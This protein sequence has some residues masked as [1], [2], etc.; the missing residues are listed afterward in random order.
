MRFPRR[1]H[2]CPAVV[3]VGRRRAFRLVASHANRRTPLER[4]YSFCF[5]IVS[6]CRLLVVAR[7][8]ADVVSARPMLSTGLAS[9]RSRRASRHSDARFAPATSQSARRSRLASRHRIDR[10]R[11]MAIRE[12]GARALHGISKG[13]RRWST[14]AGAGNAELGQPPADTTGSRRWRRRRSCCGRWQNWRHWRFVAD[15]RTVHRRLSR[16]VGSWL[17]RCLT[18]SDG[19][20]NTVCAV[21]VTVICVPQKRNTRLN[22][23]LIVFL[24]RH[25]A[26]LLNVFT[27]N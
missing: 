8:P 7:I 24:S 11:Q 9:P 27:C 14:T 16:V 21:I 10:V 19:Y 1:R 23:C 6:R 4:H 3:A 18:A 25:F 12:A 17:L 2:R 15:D 26:V 22:M 13:D 5:R 20:R